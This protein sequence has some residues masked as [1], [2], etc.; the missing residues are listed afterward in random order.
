MFHSGR[1][2]ALVQ[3]IDSRPNTSIIQVERHLCDS[4]SGSRQRVV[5]KAAAVDTPTTST[6][7]VVLGEGVMLSGLKGKALESGKVW[8]TKAEVFDAIPEHLLKRDTAKS[9]M[10]AASSLAITG[11]CFASGF[12]IPAEI[13][14]APVWLAYAAITGA[15]QSTSCVT[16]IHDASVCECPC[17]THPRV[18][19]LPRGCQFLNR[20]R[21][22]GLISPRCMWEQ[23]LF[24]PVLQLPFH[25]LQGNL[26]R[27]S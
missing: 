19:F 8:P 26:V 13:S 18:Q 23:S 6:E 25:V 3:P 2:S 16:G 17:T 14:W 24:H 10:Y 12:F 1:F 7:D 4:P 9:M 27:R 21:G 5:A 20:R 11:A 22:L 15:V